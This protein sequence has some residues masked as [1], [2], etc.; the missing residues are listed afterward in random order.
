VD[1]LS[2]TRYY[3]R[4]ATAGQAVFA[5]AP[6]VNWRKTYDRS[7]Y[8]S[9]AFSVSAEEADGEMLS[10]AGDPWRAYSD[11]ERPVVR[12]QSTGRLPGRSA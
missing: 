10:Y 4:I 2:F 11:A 9:A 8:I 12:F 3:N 7:S 1:R 5:I 6:G